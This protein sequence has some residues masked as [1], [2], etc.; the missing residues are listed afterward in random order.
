[1]AIKCTLCGSTKSVLFFEKKDSINNCDQLTI[2]PIHK[3]HGACGCFF[4]VY[5]PDWNVHDLYMGDTYHVHRQERTDHLHYENRYE[6]DME[7]SRMRIN[8]ML[9]E[10]WPTLKRG[11]TLD[12]G[13]ANGAFVETFYSEGF[14]A[15]GCDISPYIVERV[16]KSGNTHMRENKGRYFVWN[17]DDDN[18]TPSEKFNI[19]TGNDVIEHSIAPKQFMM[20]LIQLLLPGG[21]LILDTPNFSDPQFM[22]YGIWD[23]LATCQTD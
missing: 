6:H 21:L 1:M 11:Q 17:V 16:K 13:C 20:R 18:G 3:C 15:Y 19:I 22:E 8:I 14:N 4:T 5:P 2:F 9:N 23:I 12:V 10:Y 7:I